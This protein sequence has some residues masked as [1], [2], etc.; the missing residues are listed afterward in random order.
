MG[1]YAQC[2][3]S[4]HIR[5]PARQSIVFKDGS[6]LTHDKLVHY[7]IHYMRQALSVAGMDTKGYTGHSFHIGAA[8][9]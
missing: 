5:P 6:Y 8:T 7:Y 2:Q 1:I 3:P 9:T 4:W